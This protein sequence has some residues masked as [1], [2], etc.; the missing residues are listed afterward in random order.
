MHS[1]QPHS[2][3]APV[4][5]VSSR[6]VPSSYINIDMCQVFNDADIPE[7]AIPCLPPRRRPHR[8]PLSL[9]HRLHPQAHKRPRN[10]SCLCLRRLLCLA[11]RR[12]SRNAIGRHKERQ[13]IQRLI[14]VPVPVAP[15]QIPLTPT[16][17][18]PLH[19]L[20]TLLRPT[21]RRSLLHQ[22]LRNTPA[23]PYPIL[24]IPRNCP[25]PR[26]ENCTGVEES[27]YGLG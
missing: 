15:P 14:L 17:R 8:R 20:A 4:S 3:T 25:A 16:N 27:Q 24:D 5:P 10:K 19:P 9:P 12:G 11:F 7:L 2:S 23:P 18:R 26:C 22:R 13:H 6:Y 21:L 1:S